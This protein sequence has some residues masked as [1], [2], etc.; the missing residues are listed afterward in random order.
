MNQTHQT[1]NNTE[2]LEHL[3]SSLS[4]RMD[5]KSQAAYERFLKEFGVFI[6]FAFFLGFQLEHFEGGESVLAYTPTADHFNSHQVTHGGALMTL[7]DVSMACAARS[8]DPA[9]RVVTIEMKS[10][11][12]SPASGALK[13]RGHLLHRT[14]KM[15]YVETK[16]YDAQQVLCAHATGTFRFVTPR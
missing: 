14:S 3:V 5:P 13:A 15:A 8:V 12:F 9:F 1:S 6:P 16:V 11:F 10:T 2:P 7:M 4:P